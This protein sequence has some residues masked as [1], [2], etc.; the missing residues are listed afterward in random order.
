M[1]ELNF[2]TWSVNLLKIKRWKRIRRLE[3]QSYYCMVYYLSNI[4]EK[5]TE[6]TKKLGNMNKQLKTSNNEAKKSEN[7]AL[8]L[9]EN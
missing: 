1:F 4:Y 9:H 2:A 7:E 8:H 5:L 3:I 6:S